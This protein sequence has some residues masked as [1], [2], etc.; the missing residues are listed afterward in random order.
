MHEELRELQLALDLGEIGEEEYLAREEEIMARL[1]EVR[2][3]GREL[4]IP[5]ATGPF[6]SPAVRNADDA[7][8]G[9]T[10]RDPD[11][12]DGRPE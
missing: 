9:D 5:P 1:R 11:S 7:D 3:L 8:A 4:G 2:E 12:H 10:D 6:V